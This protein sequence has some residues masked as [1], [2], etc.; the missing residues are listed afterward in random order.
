[1]SSESSGAARGASLRPGRDELTPSAI[2]RALD[3]HIVGQQ[4]AKRAVAIAI[5]NRWRR[6]Q[7]SPEL[8]EE[9]M[10]KNIILIGSTGVGKTEIARRVAQLVNAP[11]IKVEAS[12]YTE[13]GYY[14]RDVESMIRDLVDASIGL[15][16]NEAL[17]EVRDR[18]SL[19]VED[20]LLDL[21]VGAEPGGTEGADVD[22]ERR[23]K[24]RE[25]FREKLRSGSLD[26]R[27]V[28]ISVESSDSPFSA[29]FSGAALEG[30]DLSALAD[31]FSSKKIERRRLPISRAR[32]VLLGQESEKLIETDRINEEAVRRAEQSGIIFLDEIDK[33]ATR[34]D[35]HGRGGE[36]S[37]EGVQR[38]L[39]PIVEGSTVHTR[40]GVVK[41]DHIL[42]I[43]AGAFHS[44]R[45][46]DLIPELQGRFPIRVEL[47]RLG[48][49]DFARILREPENALPRQ[50]AELL[51]T[52]GVK[53]RFDAT[54]IDRIAELAGE[55]NQRQEN[56]GARRLYALFE[57]LL[58]EPLFL[59]P[60][61][62]PDAG[63]EL[64][65][66]AHYVDTRLGYLVRDG[67]HG[68]YIL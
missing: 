20:R 28:E 30:I 45:P 39:L 49:E 52:E 44:A 42:F 55:I 63:R 33:I 18:A 38:D 32:E 65:V 34:S 19:S 47:E 56:I 62:L 35:A 64:T 60:D 3:R 27:E 12:K 10:P 53:I 17:A 68:S 26:D 23:R 46:S 16:R 59:A 61:A 54:G 37:R 15:V 50:Y 11:F 4:D 22:A 43:G 57:K 67:D 25:A 1:M 31:R 8:R 66:D 7:L 29:M 6:Q 36:V 9:V 48:K 51:G 2:V 21:L 5:R 14:G 13:V 40:Q 58:E 24:T 41:T